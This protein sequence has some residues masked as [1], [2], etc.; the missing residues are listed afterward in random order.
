MMTPEELGLVE[1]RRYCALLG[2]EP[3]ETLSSVARAAA[4]PPWLRDPF[5]QTS[6]AENKLRS[7]A[8]RTPRADWLTPLDPVAVL[9]TMHHVGDDLL[10][11]SV[12]RTI[13]ALPRPMGEYVVARA[14]IVSIGVRLRGFCSAPLAFEGRCWLLVVS[15]RGDSQYFRSLVAHEICHS[16]LGQEP[17][18]GV[19]CQTSF[20]DDTLLHVP[21]ADVP[22]ESVTAVSEL[23]ARQIRHEQDCQSLV[24]FL[25][26][27]DPHDFAL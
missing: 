19:V 18:P 23:R 6:A 13:A 17:D 9:T 21:I 8:A 22:A 3:D 1:Y 16:W 4:I 15:S 27:R 25:G 12:A 10:A 2:V 24:R 5:I 26:F 14:D 20:V 7:W 11:H